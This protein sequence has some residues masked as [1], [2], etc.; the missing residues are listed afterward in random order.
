MI[1][2]LHGPNLNFLA[3]RPAKYKGQITYQELISHLTEY[4]K[5]FAI[6]LICK[7][8]N[9]EGKLIDILQEFYLAQDGKGIIIN[10]GA[11][12]HTSIALHDAL[13]IF[14]IPIIEVHLSDPSQREKFRHLSYLTAISQKVIKGKGIKG[15]EEAIEELA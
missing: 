9:S 15:Y 2:L 5:K 3:Y 1:L 12:T 7:Q 8:S 13:E 11:Y 14:T 4:G 6:E 10:A